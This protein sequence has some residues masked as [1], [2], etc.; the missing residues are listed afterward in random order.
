MKAK[1]NL[2]FSILILWGCHLTSADTVEKI[3][4][5]QNWEFKQQGKTDWYPAKVPGCVHSDLIANELIK[6]PFHRVNEKEI[7]WIGEK[8]WEYKSTF[9]VDQKVLDKDNVTLNFKGLDTYADVYLNDFKILSADNMH[10]EWKKDCK[11]VLKAGENT[12]R[13]HFKSVF[14]EK[15]ED[16]LNAPFKLQAWPNND[17]NSEIWLSLYARKA[18]FHFGWDWG[19][20]LITSGI[21]RPVYLEVWND[22]K[23]ESVQIIQENVSKKSADITSIFELESTKDNAT[24]TLEIS[25]EAFSTVKKQ[26]T[27]KAGIN[28]IPVNLKMKNPKLWWSNGLGEPNLYTFDY[29]VTSGNSIDTKSI[30]TGIRSI[31]VL[32]EKEEDG[33]SFTV[34]LNGVPVFMKGA[35]YIPLH[36]FQ[37]QVTEDKYQYYIQQ[38]K[39]SNMNMIRVWGGGIYEEDIF[40]DLCDQNGLLVWQDIMFA[41]GMFPRDEEYLA[42][43]TEEVK[44]NVKRLRNHP[45]IALWNGNNENEISWYGWGW[46]DKYT[47]EE[48]KIYV[49]SLENLF[50]KVIPDAINSMD[51]TRYYHPTSPNTGYNDISENY[52]DVHLWDTKG[53]APLTIYDEVVGRFMSEYGFQSYPEMESIKKFTD[54]WERNKTSETMFAHNRARQDQTRDPNFGNQAIERKMGTYYGIPEDFENYVYRTQILHAKAT[55]IAIEAHR[56][57]MPNCMGTLY[58]QLNDC[59]PAVSWATIDFYGKWKAPQYMVRDVYENTIAPVIVEKDQLRVYIV[60]DELKEQ[61]AQLIVRMQTLAGKELM[62]EKSSITIAANTSQVYFEKKVEELLKGVDKNNVV[63][64]VSVMSGAKELAKNIFHFAPEKDLKLQSGVVKS[65]IKQSKDKTIIT[66]TASSYAKNVFLS[67]PGVDGHFSNNYF[68]ILPGETVEVEFTGA[69]KAPKGISIKSFADFTDVVN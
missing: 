31:R 26:V 3:F 53:D 15:M 24:A 47:E 6:D 45:S 57:N 16:Y 67:S 11:S 4:L 28:K 14:K 19:P 43:V 1:F 62:K 58:W 35:N 13:I 41:C 21:W 10:R 18:G 48:Q 40:Y 20:R 50:Y 33:Q 8:D 36:N 69:D 38:A 65:E 32:R 5:H 29:K 30:T 22:V 46:K 59:W 44:D 39:V 55:K 25:S 64:D 54:D 34:E 12:L 37:D 63:L 49:A 17:Q 66:L 9:K 51:E 68:D 42:N 56:R 60:T 2:F 27:L 52:G 23:L 7:Q 61:K